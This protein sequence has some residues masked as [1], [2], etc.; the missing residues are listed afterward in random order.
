[1]WNSSNGCPEESG[2]ISA[3]RA[4]FRGRVTDKILGTALPK[5][6]KQER[7][8][9]EWRTD[10]GAAVGETAKAHFTRRRKSIAES[11]RFHMSGPWIFQG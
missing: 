5:W 1:M 9:M 2:P 10:S 7:G 4:A 8:R 11:S 6:E 3:K